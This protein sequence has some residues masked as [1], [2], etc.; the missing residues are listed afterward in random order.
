MT[1]LGLSFPVATD[2]DS[3]RALLRSVV[4]N[5]G[6]VWPPW[7]GR[8]P[9]A[10]ETI[11]TRSAISHHLT[12]DQGQG[13]LVRLASAAM[14][15]LR[16]VTDNDRELLPRTP[17]SG[18]RLLG[19]AGGMIRTDLAQPLNSSLLA[20]LTG[21][22][23]GEVIVIQWLVAPLRPRHR[24]PAE[25]AI[26]RKKRSELEVVA[27]GRVAASAKS[28]ERARSLVGR[29]A[30][31]YPQAS[32]E[33][34][35]LRLRWSARVPEDVRRRRPPFWVW[36]SHLNIDELL[37]LLAWPVGPLPIPGLGRG[38]SRVLPPPIELPPSGP[39]VAISNF[40][41][42]TARI[43]LGSE[44]RLRHL[45]VIG[46]TGVG[47]STLLARLIVSDIAAGAG[48]VAIDPLGDLTDLIAERLPEHRVGDLMV[49]DPT[50]ANL[51]VGYNLLSTTTTP[52][53]VEFV[54]GA[55]SQL[56]ASSWGPRTADILRA[57][58]LTLSANRGTTLADL[59]ELLINPAKR[60]RLVPAVADDRL[61]A[62]FWQWYEQLSANERPTVI[63][64]LLN[65][66][67]SWLLRP[68]L[69][70]TVCH[71][72]G[73]LSF[74]EVF[75]QQRIVILR[76]P[77]GILGEEIAG[78]I[79]ALLLSTLWRSVLAR[80]AVPPN[81]RRPVF[82]Y[83]DEF[84]DYL[85]LPIGL[86][87]LLSQARNMGVSVV[88]AHQYLSQLPDST[89]RD[90]LANVGSRVI[91]RLGSADARILARDL[92]PYLTAAD[93]GGL[94]SREVV[95]SIA[96]PDRVSPPATGRT[97]PLLPPTSDAKAV[98]IEAAKRYGRALPAPPNQ[99]PEP[100]IGRRPRRAE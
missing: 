54:I 29:L 28:T 17:S 24:R 58:L 26:D 43:R 52:Q 19:P 46:P 87:D 37:G 75:T 63:A 5:T 41:G 93:L 71:P 61:L 99:A 49:V 64:P 78:L 83:L 55:M 16:I 57:G 97:L 8:G 11:A 33:S 34:G 20:A 13:G 59:P 74:A 3:L 85:R 45:H 86:G 90:V 12:A 82:I 23:G 18:V 66:L 4:S 47:K 89:R 39:A 44:G 22:Q 36:P 98:R 91:F 53:S 92:D 2:V 72:T 6:R 77:K 65:K 68:E 81:R 80:A 31:L 100:P 76:L 1:S 95:A 25:E 69:V 40:P 9:L 67:R 7:A 15:G 70:R 21:L 10:I 56:F 60:L 88:A 38:L 32:G 48:L 30:R 35:G 84:Q 42:R 96:L 27:A 73:Q 14:P 62:G 94:G 79:G 51:P 50:D